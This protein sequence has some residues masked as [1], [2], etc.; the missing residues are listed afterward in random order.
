MRVVTVGGGPA[1]LYAS[2]LLKKVE[3]RNE[4]TVFERN[5]AGATY[6]WG[7]VFS[8]RT[9]TEF[10]EADY[11]T[12][13]QIT[14]RFVQWD[15]IDV[16]LRGDLVR[17]G[18]HVFA[19]I[20]RKELLGILRRRCEELGVHIGFEQT[21]DDLGELPPHDVLIGADGVGSTVRRLHE[22]SFR[23]SFE[24]GRARYIWYGTDRALDSF[25]F[26]F[27]ESKHGL[28]Q[29][30]A[31]PFDGTTST[32]IVECSEETWRRAG[33]DEADEGESIAFCERLFADDLLGNPL[34]S[35]NSRWLTF[36]TLRCRSWRHGSVVLLGDAA[37]T[38]HF[39]IGSGTK[40]AMED[41]ISLARAFEH[42]GA[43]ADAALAD[44][45]LERKPVV[46]RFQEAAAESR[47]YFETTDRYLHL[48]PQQFAFHL[49]SRSGRIDY[50]VLRIRDPGYADGV[51][52]WF[53]TSAGAASAAL[54]PPP[55]FTPIAWG[56]LH[57]RNRV[58]VSPAPRYS[59]E[60]GLPSR[61]HHADLLRAAE[62]GAALVLT[63]IVAVSPDARITSGD[64]GLYRD[65][66]AE[67]W[68]PVVDEVHR[69]GA[70]VGLRL[71][72]AGRRGSTRPR[73]DGL[74]RPLREGGWD[75]VSAS[76]IPFR[77][78]GPVPGELDRGGMD[79][80]V[81]AF[82]SAARRGG[83]AGFD[84]LELNMA[85]GYLLGS[86]LSPLTNVRS[87]EFGGSLEERMRFPLNVLRA[88]R[89]AWPLDKPLA[90]AINATDWTPG[91]TQ[92]DDAVALARALAEAGCDIVEILAGH[93]TPDHR[94]RYGR[95]FLVALADRVRN[96][97]RVPTLVGGGIT[98]T[99]QANTVLAGGRADLVVMDLLP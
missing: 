72:H 52:R 8:D 29:V 1:G 13:R 93:I 60:D 4:I 74:D 64:A 84:L 30:H 57:L 50:D 25:T 20:A 85:H 5:L 70:R 73:Q 48:S 83:R 18:G 15:A 82:V 59:A 62:S 43:D 56:T 77:H 27:R 97:A 68:A 58:T 90:A 36:T 89:S 3:P 98:T 76:A 63:E 35:N 33:L 10:R 2:L 11:A 81:T 87:D 66:H 39:S 26:I 54:A 41:A 16:L 22:K 88:V 31:Y 42:H 53:A 12:Y 47:T 23:P 51:D 79:R 55:A 78:D 40:L 95:L 86:F 80:I 37:H 46:E 38:A 61:A 9:L 28:F 94:P 65:D 17:S 44:Y 24:E 34:L 7:V 21:V 32:W 6:G 69:A 49:L 67:G 96:E 75:L 92:V 91:G 71:G 19:G 99:G 45:E 14:D